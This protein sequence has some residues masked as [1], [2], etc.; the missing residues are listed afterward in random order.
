MGAIEYLLYL[1]GLLIMAFVVFRIIVRRD[2]LKKG[3]L[4]WMAVSLETLI[5]ALH[6]NFSYFF[7]YNPQKVY[8]S[9]FYWYS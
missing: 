6:A 8:G 4:G 1:C 5:F 3:K 2:Y 9:F 7:C